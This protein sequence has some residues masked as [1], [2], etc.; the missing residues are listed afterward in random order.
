MGTK[1]SDLPP[2]QTYKTGYFDST[3]K[4]SWLFSALYYI[5]LNETISDLVTMKCE[6]PY[7][8]MVKQ[9]LRGPPA[10]TAYSSWAM[11]KRLAQLCPHSS[12]WITSS[13]T[14]Y[15]SYRELIVKGNKN[16]S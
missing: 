12:R 7:T 6:L 4:S 1:C 2:A 11:N 10:P 5:P 3:G 15:C 13:E 16:H 8:G 9:T 14:T